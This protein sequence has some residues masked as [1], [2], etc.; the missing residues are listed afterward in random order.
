MNDPLERH[1][2]I[3]LE[4][5]AE[6]RTFAELGAKYGLSTARVHQVVVGS[7]AR[8]GVTGRPTAASVGLAIQRRIANSTRDSCVE[9]TPEWFHNCLK[10]E[11]EEDE[12][13]AMYKNLD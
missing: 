3:T 13:L 4:H 2:R 12:R 10:V 8:L 11:R 1:F 9:G 7:Y 6:G 5:L